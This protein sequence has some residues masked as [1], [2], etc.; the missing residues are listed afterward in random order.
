MK[1]LPRTMSIVWFFLVLAALTVIA[2]LAIQKKA[3]GL[4]PFTS[5]QPDQPTHR[6]H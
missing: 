3:H 1:S 4:A 6:E 2:H 5:E